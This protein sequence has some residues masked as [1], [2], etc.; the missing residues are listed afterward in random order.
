MCVT[1][2]VDGLLFA[3][4]GLSIQ[5]TLQTPWM[6]GLLSLLF[7][8]LAVCLLAGHDLRLPQKWMHKMAL[9][10]EHQPRGHFWGVALIGAISA[11][12]VS[13]CVSAPLVGALAYISQTHNVGLGGAALFC[14]SLGMGLPLIVFNTFGAHYIPKTG[15]WMLGIKKCFA[16]IFLGMAIWLVSRLLP[17]AL[18]LSL[19]GIWLLLIAYTSGLFT[20]T[21]KK[22][23]LFRLRQVLGS[24]CAVYGIL[25]IIG[26]SLGHSNLWLP[27]QA[28]ASTENKLNFTTVTT[29]DDLEAAIQNA[30]GKP[31]FIDFY[32]D[33]CLSCKELERDFYKPEVNS[34]L[35]QFHLVRVNMT[36]P[37]ADMDGILRRWQVIA[38]PTLIIVNAQGQALTAPIVG[39]VK[40]QVLQEKLQGVLAEQR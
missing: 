17:S 25:L 28:S 20:R 10:S 32:A 6:I 34:L 36:R 35:Q 16:F 24:V 7:V 30:D 23:F 1:Y 9:L 11:L 38:P 13:P 18:V 22:S 14:L 29:H 39:A 40:S 4:L 31:V 5:S 37:S 26:A 3:L 2:T 12:I 21:Q 33:W 27:L 15:P 8:V 19:W